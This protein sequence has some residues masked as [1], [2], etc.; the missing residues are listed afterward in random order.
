MLGSQIAVWHL[1]GITSPWAF[2]GPAA[3]LAVGTSMIMKQSTIQHEQQSTMY[4]S[5]EEQSPNRFT[6]TEDRLSIHDM[7]SSSFTVVTSMQ[8]QSGTITSRFSETVV[9]LRHTQLS[10]D[11]FLD[12]DVLFGSVK[13]IVSQDIYTKINSKANIFSSVNKNIDIPL[14]DGA[15]KLTLN[16]TILFGEIEIEYV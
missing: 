7:F 12:I 15:Q 13:I 8:L 11:V 3:I 9:D 1:R 6:T 14:R 16:T 4:N 10:G 2:A 5:Q